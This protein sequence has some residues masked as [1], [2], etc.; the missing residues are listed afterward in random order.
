MS[1]A[2]LPRRAKLP[3]DLKESI[4][5]DF[6]YL[7]KNV[8]F[9]EV[10]N[11]SSDIYCFA[12]MYLELK[13]TSPERLL[14]M[15]RMSTIEQFRSINTTA[16]LE[17]KL[18]KS[19]CQKE[20]KQLIRKCLDSNMSVRPSSLELWREQNRHMEKTSRRFGMVNTTLTHR[21]IWSSYKAQHKLK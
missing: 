10:Y 5:G 21:N 11:S 7:P 20:F 15:E 14:Q 3:A 17:E 1:G 4:S 2:C 9:G 18:V 6:V 8:L 13:T 19:V 12:L 16:V